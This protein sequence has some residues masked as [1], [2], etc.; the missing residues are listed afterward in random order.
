MTRLG[1]HSIAPLLALALASC[2]TAAPAPLPA[3][4]HAPAD[5]QPPRVALVLG[6][7]GARGFA[8][9]G[10]IRVLEDAGVPVELVV[11]TSVGSLVGALYATDTNSVELERTART[12]ERSDFFDFGLSPAL[13]GTG[14]ATGRRLEKFVRQ[15]LPEA[16]IE[17]LRVPYAA[18]AT[19]LDTG[20]TVVLREGDVARAVRAS[21]AIPGVFEPVT[22]DGR[23]LVDGGVTL[24]LPVK[25]ARDMGADV[26]IA[27]DLSAV[28]PLRPPDNFVEVIMRAVNIRVHGEVEQAR[29]TSDVLITPEVGKVGMID[30][31]RKDEA[32]AAGVAAAR[33]ALPE[34]QR[35][36][37]EGSRRQA[38][39]AR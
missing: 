6:G 15:H 18:V 8:H 4:P 36:L 32:I 10:V 37:R 23:L 34:I 19:D 33:A 13:F 2:R 24:N 35:V 1:P 27:V 29:Q 16:R 30:F 26:I 38:A 39:A 12:L 14:L 31:D 28:E 22:W 17:Q 20:E 3:I 9:V 11:G 25:V 21:C 5:D 7:G